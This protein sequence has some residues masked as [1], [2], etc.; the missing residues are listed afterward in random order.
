MCKSHSV[1]PIDACFGFGKRVAS[2][3]GRL[4]DIG[5]VVE[6]AESRARKSSSSAE[7]ILALALVQVPEVLH[8]GP[9]RRHC[10]C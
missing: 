4:P 10:R 7:V 5:I 9:T 8:R 1:L 2:R 6:N 3:R